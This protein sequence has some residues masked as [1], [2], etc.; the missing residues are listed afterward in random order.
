MQKPGS[1]ISSNKSCSK[2][3]IEYVRK[4]QN[5]RTKCITFFLHPQPASSNAPLCP[6]LPDIALREPRLVQSSA[7]ALPEEI[8][9]QCC[10]EMLGHAQA[11]SN[12]AQD[13]GAL[14]R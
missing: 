7:L 9:C 4:T 6:F 12:S 2:T 14:I 8:L 13:I 11:L 1:N 3:I 5:S 10:I